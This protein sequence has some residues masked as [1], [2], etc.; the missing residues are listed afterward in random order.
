MQ[1]KRME[2]KLLLELSKINRR[3]YEGRILDIAELLGNTKKMLIRNFSAGIVRGMGMGIGFYLIT[4]I[5]VYFM[6][7]IIKLNIPLISNYIS[8][9]VAI[10]E[11]R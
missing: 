11:R 6:Q 2:E 4:A 1:I 7:K 10:V 8:D 9:I 5:I 3:L